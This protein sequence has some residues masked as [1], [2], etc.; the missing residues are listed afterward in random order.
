MP[1]KFG[2]TDL[3]NFYGKYLIDYAQIE[4][5]MTPPLLLLKTV[6]PAFSS[7]NAGVFSY[8]RTCLDKTAPHLQD[9]I[10]FPSM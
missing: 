2:L 1:C 7:Q 4:S 8:P 6:T 5:G 3:S 10:D 9:L